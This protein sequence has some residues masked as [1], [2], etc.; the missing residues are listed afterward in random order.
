M[1]FPRGVREDAADAA[2]AAAASPPMIQTPAVQADGALKTSQSSV[3]LDMNR[4]PSGGQDQRAWGLDL[5]PLALQVLLPIC[6]VELPS[7]GRGV[8]W[9]PL[10]VG[11]KEHFSN[12]LKNPC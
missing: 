11:G 1:S 2:E 7:L 10:L 4:K 6:Q 5:D 12:I 8:K 3:L 9:I